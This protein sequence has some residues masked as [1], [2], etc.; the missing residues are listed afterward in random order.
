MT[1][2]FFTDMVQA[3]EDYAEANVRIE[4]TDVFIKDQALNTDEKMEARAK[5]INNGPLNMTNVILR[6]T[7]LNGAQVAHGSL[8]ADFEDEIF[9]TPIRRSAATA[10][11]SSRW[12]TRS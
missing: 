4:I 3:V 2:T 12:M 11:L 5:V 7:A 6:I 9:T 10:V 8:G 1:S